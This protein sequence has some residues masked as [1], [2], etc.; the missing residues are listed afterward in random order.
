MSHTGEYLPIIHYHNRTMSSYLP[1]AHDADYV[2]TLFFL[3]D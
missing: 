3:L 1:H 2:I